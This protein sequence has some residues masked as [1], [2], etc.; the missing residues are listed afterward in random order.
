MPQ[1]F[2]IGFAFFIA[3]VLYTSLPA[4]QNS[5]ISTDL[6]LFILLVLKETVI[7]L[8]MGFTGTA[9]FMAVQVA[10]Q[11]VDMQIGFSIVNVF[12]PQMGIQAPLLGNFNNLLALLLFIGLDG[13]YILLT[14]LIQSYGFVPIGHLSISGS[15]V[16]LFI[17]L[18][19]ALLLLGLKLAMPVLAALFLTDVAFAIVARA[20]PQMNI[21]IV[22]MPLKIGIGLLVLILT[23]PAM[24]YLLKNLFNYGFQALD[25]LF[26]VLGG[27]T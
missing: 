12:D 24:V 15:V 10:G 17:K 3:L 25:S 4:I 20:V 23:M 11:L 8:L 6:G 9:I 19:S 13:P 1:S 7:G 14:G 21:Y 16:E 27:T 18:V 5:G 22:G 2:K 26:H